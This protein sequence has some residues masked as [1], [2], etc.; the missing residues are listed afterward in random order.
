MRRL[1]L[2]HVQQDE[3]LSRGEPLLLAIQK[4]DSPLPD[5]FGFGAR[6]YGSKPPPESTVRNVGDS[7]LT[8]SVP[9]SVVSQTSPS[10][11]WDGFRVGGSSVA[12]TEHQFFAAEPS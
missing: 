6:L 11:G 12:V 10:R 8:R 3:G 7:V 2:I 1:R 5:V 9:S 4:I